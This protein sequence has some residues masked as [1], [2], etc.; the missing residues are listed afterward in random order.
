MPSCQVAQGLVD[1]GEL[2]YIPYVAPLP[3]VHYHYDYASTARCM[4]CYLK[5]YWGLGSGKK[6][7]CLMAYGRRVLCSRC[8][9]P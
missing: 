2:Y 9:L 7:P 1:L 4:T 5:V 3:L 6:L 8:T